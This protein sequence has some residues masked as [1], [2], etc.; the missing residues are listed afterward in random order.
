MRVVGGLV[1]TP[2][3]QID[4][5]RLAGIVSSLASAGEG[6]RPEERN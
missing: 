5:K 2:A 3:D 1:I 4:S 6:A